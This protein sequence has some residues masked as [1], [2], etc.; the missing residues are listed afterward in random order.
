MSN[1]ALKNKNEIFELEKQS[2]QENYPDSSWSNLRSGSFEW[3]M[4]KIL[5]EVSELNG[6]YLDQRAKNAYLED[7]NLRKAVRKIAKNLGM[8]VSERVG[9]T[10]T[11]TITASDTVTIPIGS[12][13]PSSNGQVFVS[14]T[15]LLLENSNSYTGDVRVINGSYKL[16]NERAKGD[17][18]EEV[19]IAENDVLVD[20]LIVEVNGTEWERTGDL[21][22]TNSN[23]AV[24]LVEF[25]ELDRSSG[26]FVS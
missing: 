8:V 1:L 19:F 9:A 3:L 6:F 16:V 20:E 7:A 22:G 12:R 13:F 21:S 23:S 14:L 24:Y 15:E 25:D 4:A 11:L 26:K 17:A 18:N 2:A 10:T 5:A